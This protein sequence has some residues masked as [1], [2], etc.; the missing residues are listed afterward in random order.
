LSE[1]VTKFHKA[2]IKVWL[3]IK[4]KSQKTKVVNKINLKNKK[5]RK[6]VTKCLKI[7]TIE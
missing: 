4:D 1:E 2:L 3:K 7:E 5:L 6:E